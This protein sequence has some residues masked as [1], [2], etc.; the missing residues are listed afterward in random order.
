MWGRWKLRRERKGVGTIV[1]VKRVGVMLILA[2]IF[3]VGL[4]G[5]AATAHELGRDSVDGNEIRWEDSTKWDSAR[6]NAIRNWERV[7]CLTIAPDNWRT[8]TDLEFRDYRNANTNTT[9][10]W[11][12]RWGADRIYMN[13]HWMDQNNRAQ[14]NHNM[15]HELGHATGLDHNGRNDSVMRQGRLELNDLGRHDSA[16]HRDM[17]C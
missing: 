4:L 14:R 6:R 12:Q 16:D 8:V 15:L 11:Q 13:D 7:G 3:N 17:W 9:G 2:V 1:P 5:G 10:Y